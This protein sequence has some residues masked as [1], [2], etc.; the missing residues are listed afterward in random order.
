MPPLTVDLIAERTAVEV[1]GA[2]V[3]YV[4]MAVRNSDSVRDGVMPRSAM[5][6]M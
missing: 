5:V 1:W 6:A 4:V 2:S 3:L